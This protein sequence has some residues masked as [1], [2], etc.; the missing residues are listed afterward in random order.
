MAVG[1]FTEGKILSPLVKFTLPVLAALFLQSLYGAVDLLIVCD[2][3]G[4]FGGFDGFAVD[5]G[6]YQYDCGSCDGYDGTHRSADRKRRKRKCR[7]D[8]GRFDCLLHS[9]GGCFD[10]GD[11]TECSE[12]CQCDEGA[13]GG[14]LRYL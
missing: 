4:C 14:V 12:S 3:C 11:V 10:R 2:E 1:N 9:A 8:D 7:Q 13:D 6:H 5:V